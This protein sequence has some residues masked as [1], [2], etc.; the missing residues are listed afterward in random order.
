MRSQEDVLKFNLSDSIKFGVVDINNQII[1]PF[2]YN[3][4]SKYNDSLYAVR[5]NNK[6]GLISTR[7][8]KPKYPFIYDLILVMP[9]DRDFRNF[10]S[11]FIDDSG[12]YNVVKDSLYTIIDNNGKEIFTPKELP[13]Y[14]TIDNSVYLVPEDSLY[15]LK[16]ISGKNILPDEYIAEV[17]NYRKRLTEV[18]IKNKEGKTT[19]YNVKSQKFYPPRFYDD[20][21]FAYNQEDNIFRVKKDENKF[22]VDTLGNRITPL[23]FN[24]IIYYPEHTI[25]FGYKK[26]SNNTDDPKEQVCLIGRKQNILTPLYDYI[27]YIGLENNIL[28]RA[29]LNGKVGIIN[30]K[31]DIIAPFKYSYI[32]SFDRKTKKAIACTE[33]YKKIEILLD[34]LGKEYPYNTET[35]KGYSNEDHWRDLNQGFTWICHYVNNGG[36]RKSALVN[37]NDEILTPY[38]Y[39]HGNDGWFVYRNKIIY[40]TEEGKG[41]MDFSGKQLTPPIYDIIRDIGNG[42]YTRLKDSDMFY[43]LDDDLNI[44][45]PA[46]KDFAVEREGDLFQVLYRENP[47]KPHC[48]S[49]IKRLG[50]EVLLPTIYEDIFKG[51]GYE[52]IVIKNINRNN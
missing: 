44:L 35:Y 6:W 21:D 4:I 18:K 48:F 1:I 31:G 10:K 19:F 5:K 8:G 17:S 30:A 46:S 40:T 41:F 38:E 15:F 47:Y 52:F 3:H 36:W 28:F 33:K 9:S 2:E 11:W 45:L 39:I 12:F 13:I 29:S 49:G 26:I 32:H 51:I 22:Y 27:N 14:R 16:D 20:I 43:C 37:K 23:G 34:T 7:T 42:F 50:G 25:F 24:N